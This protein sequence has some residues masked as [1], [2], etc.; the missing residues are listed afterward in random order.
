MN[1][2]SPKF[3]VHTLFSRKFMVLHLKIVLNK[4]L[5]REST[6]ISPLY[7]HSLSYYCKKSAALRMQRKISSQLLHMISY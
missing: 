2:N 1:A 5:L 7:F 4:M 6:G 3:N